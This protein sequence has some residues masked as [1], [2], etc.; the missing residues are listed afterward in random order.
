MG[1]QPI[2]FFRAVRFEIRI[3]GS[4]KL[5]SRPFAREMAQPGEMTEAATSSPCYRRYYRRVVF[6]RETLICKNTVSVK[7]VAGRRS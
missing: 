4:I 6:R 7:T 5:I 3:M 1:N 2:D